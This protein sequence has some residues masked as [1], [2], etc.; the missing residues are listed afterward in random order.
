MCRPERSEG[1]EV[2]EETPAET[3]QAIVV[4]SS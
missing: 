1:E 3:N 2:A 4:T